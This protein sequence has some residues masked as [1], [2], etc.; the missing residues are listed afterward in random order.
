L[1]GLFSSKQLSVTPVSPVHEA[2]VN[3]NSSHG[4]GPLPLLALKSM[5]KLS[6]NPKLLE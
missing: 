4:N 6:Q 3:V 5:Y 1:I 2:V